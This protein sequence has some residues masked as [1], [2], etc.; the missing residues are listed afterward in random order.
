MTIPHRH[1]DSHRPPRRTGPMSR[2][3]LITNL[4]AAG[5]G[6]TIFGAC[7]GSD[8]DGAT[9]TPTAGAGTDPPTTDPPATQPPGTDP[10][11]T[12]VPVTDPPP[13]D[14]PAT[15][16]A[17][18]EQLQLQ[19]VSLGFVS[20]FVLLRGNE[21][22]VVDTGVPGSA[23]SILGGL[24]LLGA[25]WSDV[26]HVVLTHYHGD[27]VGGL[28]EV[29]AE[30]PG[31]TLYG[32]EADIA[33]IQSA[34][35]IMAG[36]DGDEVLGLGVVN[37]PGHTPGSIS[38]FDTATGILV[39]GD[40]FTGMDGVLAEPPPQFTEDVDQAVASIAKLAALQ[41]QLAAFGHTG[42]P[43]TTDVT[44]QLAALAAS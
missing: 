43:I 23:A 32:G 30:A 39:A 42:P 2:R 25:S 41:P 34:A 13:T 35:P 31:A 10:P 19:H 12:D 27:H 1:H 15:D 4:G 9:T 3:A 11:A 14:P 40:A 8:G 5:L 37:T 22:A 36:G 21:A 18:G 20:A 7:G 17:T 44:A 38:L 16:P 29:I 6:L 28:A 33:A 24:E 26:G